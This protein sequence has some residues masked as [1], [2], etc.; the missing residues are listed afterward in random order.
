VDM[1][2][3]SVG[4]DDRSGEWA[5]GVGW[6][7]GERVVRLSAEI[8]GLAGK[9]LQGQLRSVIALPFA[10]LATPA[11]RPRL[12]FPVVAPLIIMVQIPPFT[13]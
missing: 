5:P 1:V 11:L 4:R 13:T 10:L 6:V 7:R 9:G 2:L 3:A 12:R 8:A